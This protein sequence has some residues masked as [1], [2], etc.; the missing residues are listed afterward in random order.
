MDTDKED[1]V[2]AMSIG[3]KAEIVYYGRGSL[4]GVL[5]SKYLEEPFEFYSLV[6]MIEKMEEVFDA[7]KFPST[8]LKTRTFS[9]VKNKAKKGGAEGSEAA[10]EAV[11]PI[12]FENM[13]GTANTFEITVRF[14]QNATWQ[15]QILWV[16]EKLRQDFR[17][18]L[19]MLKLID[20]AITSGE[21]DEKPVVWEE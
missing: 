14:R 21:E 6:R 18:V 9:S 5:H 11:S 2:T 20:E 3:M 4:K 16:E 8:F 12:P 13:Q 17:C 7:K 10:R 19:E 15:G 1:I